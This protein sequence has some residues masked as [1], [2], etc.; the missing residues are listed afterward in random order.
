[1]ERIYFFFNFFYNLLSVLYIYKYM[2]FPI[3]PIRAQWDSNLYWDKQD[4]IIAHAEVVVKVAG[5]QTFM[6]LK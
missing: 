5:D 3:S 2:H 1:M 6:E 4:Q